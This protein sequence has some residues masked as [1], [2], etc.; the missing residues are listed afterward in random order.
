[1]DHFEQ[2]D[3]Q[4]FGDRKIGL[5]PWRRLAAHH[6]L[7]QLKALAWSKAR[8]ERP[9]GVGLVGISGPIDRTQD[10]AA[11]ED[12]AVARR[13]RNRDREK[14]G[15]TVAEGFAGGINLS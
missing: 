8:A 3:A 15:G 5:G 1:Q 12:Q 14:S 2:G 7:P 11:E 6:F 10:F 9:A 4:T 13:T